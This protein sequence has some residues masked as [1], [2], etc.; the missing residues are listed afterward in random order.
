MSREFARTDSGPKRAPGRKLQPESK[1]TPKMATSTGLASR[2]SSSSS[3][4]SP[5]W[6]PSSGSLLLCQRP[7]G[8]AQRPR[9]AVPRLLFTRTLAFSTS[10]SSTPSRSP[11]LKLSSQ[12]QVGFRLLLM[13]GVFC[14]ASPMRSTTK[15]SDTSPRTP[16]S[17]SRRPR[18]ES[19]RTRRAAA[20]AAC[21][22]LTSCSCGSLAKV[23]MPL[24]RGCTA[25]LAGPTT[26]PS[27]EVRRLRFWICSVLGSGPA[28]PSRSLPSPPEATGCTASPRPTTGSGRG[29]TSSGVQSKSAA[30]PACSRQW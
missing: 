10:S 4:S 14:S 29:T 13:V 18:A 28:G 5:P 15:G 20:E 23:L 19:T 26:C 1:G 12:F 30:R 21:S 17:R 11:T 6:P 25:G 27:G 3:S 24:N 16:V 8:R 2:S 7:A 9:R 22:A